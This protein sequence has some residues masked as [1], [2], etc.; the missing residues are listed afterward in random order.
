[1]AQR[2]VIAPVTLA[3]RDFEQGACVCAWIISANHDPEHF[4]Q[5]DRFDMDRIPNRHLSFRDGG[6][7]GWLGAGLARLVARLTLAA[8]GQR[9]SRFE[10]APG[11]AAEVA[12]PGEPEDALVQAAYGGQQPASAGPPLRCS[13]TRLAVVLQA[14]D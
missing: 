5:P 13:L 8:I 9:F 14:S 2:T 6:A 1:M 11:D 7:F 4:T 10:L 12:L 3:G